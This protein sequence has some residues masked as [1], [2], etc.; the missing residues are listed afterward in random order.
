MKKKLQFQYYYKNS[1]CKAN[2][3]KDT[4]CICWHDEGTGLYKDERHDDE[5]PVVEWRIKPIN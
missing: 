3:S 5:T 4:N 2:T 1:E